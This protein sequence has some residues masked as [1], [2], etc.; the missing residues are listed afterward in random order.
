MNALPGLASLV[1]S[2]RF[3]LPVKVEVV[4]KGLDSIEKGLG[5]LMKGVVVPS[6]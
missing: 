6:M 1:E 3:E 2:G 4:G 5:K